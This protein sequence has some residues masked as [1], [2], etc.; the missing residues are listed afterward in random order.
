[1]NDIPVTMTTCENP[2]AQV[3]YVKPAGCEFEI[4]VDTAHT[5]N[6]QHQ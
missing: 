5:R 2:R 3:G 1:M 4:R 6:L